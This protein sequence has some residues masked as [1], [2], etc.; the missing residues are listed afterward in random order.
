MA[1]SR[2]KKSKQPH[3]IHEEIVK[4]TTEG[5]VALLP[6]LG[7]LGFH[8]ASEPT[9]PEEIPISIVVGPDNPTAHFGI[10]PKFPDPEDQQSQ[11]VIRIIAESHAEN[12]SALKYASMIQGAFGSSSITIESALAILLTLIA[13][14]AQ[15]VFENLL[16]DSAEGTSEAIKKFAR[17][18]KQEFESILSNPKVDQPELDIKAGGFDRTLTPE[19]STQ[20]R[21]L[22]LEL[23][24]R[25]QHP[26]SRVPLDDR[27]VVAFQGVAA[28]AREA[29]LTR[30]DAASAES[31]A[32]YLRYRA[33]DEALLMFPSGIHVV[34]LQKIVDAPIAP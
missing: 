23:L 31:L 10:D 6:I 20:V 25:S 3:S 27:T 33:A 13:K 28:V 34:A 12:Q 5:L 16:D 19:A 26:N 22:G 17:K 24:Q 32:G 14:Y 29:F 21:A 30:L 1:S 8:A 4:A 2:R 7:L 15:K 9:V 11:H 18:L